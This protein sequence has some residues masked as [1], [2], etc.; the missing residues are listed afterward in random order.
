MAGN[1][2]LNSAARAKKDEFYTQ[3]ADLEQ[4]FADLGLKKIIAT[5]YAG[6]PEVTDDT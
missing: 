3:I 2:T 1:K 5:C 6:S 4:N